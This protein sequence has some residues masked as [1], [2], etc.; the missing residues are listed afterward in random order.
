MSYSVRGDKMEDYTM[1]DRKLGDLSERME[2][3][4]SDFIIFCK[5]EQIPLEMLVLDMMDSVKCLYMAVLEASGN[6]N[7]ELE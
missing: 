5:Q 2:S 3:V 1:I 7:P 4:I 6:Q